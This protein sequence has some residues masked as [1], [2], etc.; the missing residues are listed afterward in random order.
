MGSL[1]MAP[2]F[3]KYSDLGGYK[4]SIIAIIGIVLLIGIVAILEP[5]Q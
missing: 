2:Q 3:N 5:V 4:L 1:S